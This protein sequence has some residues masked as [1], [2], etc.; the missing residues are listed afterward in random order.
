M[1][2]ADVFDSP[3]ETNFTGILFN[4]STGIFEPTKYPDSYEYT[5]S[6]T[7]GANDNTL[8]VDSEG[9]WIHV[10]PYDPNTK[11]GINLGELGTVTGKATINITGNTLVQGFIF[12]EEGN[13]TNVQS[14]GVFGGGDSSAALG[15]TE[16]NINVSGQKTNYAYNTYNVYGGGN[17]A[18]V[19]GNTT[20]NLQGNTE[21]YGNVFGGGNKGVVSGSTTVNI[22]E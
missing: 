4:T 16:V 21:I 14:G 1:P 19:G 20:V 17:L 9:K 18:G 3:T 13:I 8:V 6:N 5:W 11:K 2:T 7:K 15:D 10:D 22:M 12:D